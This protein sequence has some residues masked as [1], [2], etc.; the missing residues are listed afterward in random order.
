MCLLS[1][2]NMKAVI[3]NA[4]VLSQAL[5][6]GKTVPFEITGGSENTLQVFYDEKNRHNQPSIYFLTSG[7]SWRTFLPRYKWLRRSHNFIYCKII[8]RSFMLAL[9]QSVQ[10]TEFKGIQNLFAVKQS[11]LCLWFF[12]RLQKFFLNSFISYKHNPFNIVL[13]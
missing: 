6:P 13:W 5:K 2:P 9:P 7:R 1:S 4:S 12:S 8:S 11:K 10:I 3:K